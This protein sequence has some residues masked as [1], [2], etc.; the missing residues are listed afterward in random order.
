MPAT[1][2]IKGTEYNGYWVTI[3]DNNDTTQYIQIPKGEI[4]FKS[5]DVSAGEIHLISDVSVS[6]IL[7]NTDANTLDADGNLL[8]TSDKIA[9]Y[10]STFK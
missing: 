8:D 1:G 9:Q 2:T 3:L 10:L 6:N 7:V 4:Y 5:T